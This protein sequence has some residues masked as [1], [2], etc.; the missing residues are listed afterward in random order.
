MEG[1]KA[2]PQTERARHEG[3]PSGSFAQGR[4]LWGSDAD[5]ERLHAG[6]PAAGPRLAASAAHETSSESPHF[7]A[8]LT[9][10]RRRKSLWEGAVI[11]LQAACQMVTGGRGHKP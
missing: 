11:E 6:R 9:V 8:S 4:S 3:S 5:K 10:N 2:A 1:G 7:R